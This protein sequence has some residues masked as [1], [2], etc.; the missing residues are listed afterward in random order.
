MLLHSIF[1]CGSVTGV[2]YKKNKIQMKH[3]AERQ[4]RFEVRRLKDIAQYEDVQK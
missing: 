3:S 1:G 2:A 4:E